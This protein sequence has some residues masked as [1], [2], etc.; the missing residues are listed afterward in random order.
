MLS[1]LII[2]VTLMAQAKTEPLPE[3]TSVDYSKLAVV[4]ILGVLAAL[5]ER[6]GAMRKRFS[7]RTS[8][9]PWRAA[10]GW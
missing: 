1:N 2:A 7:W 4:T 9:R 8:T 3:G 6:E 10:N 5:R